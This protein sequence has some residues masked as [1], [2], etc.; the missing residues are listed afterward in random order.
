MALAS[1][2]V[3]L[4]PSPL[5]LGG[6]WVNR[7]RVVFGPLHGCLLDSVGVERG[8]GRPGERPWRGFFG[9]GSICD[10]RFVGFDGF[11][12]VGGSRWQVGF[13][14]VIERDRLLGQV[15]LHI[16]GA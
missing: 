8:G 9:P 16:L 3:C 5:G 4:G 1:V 2:V 15:R 10:L 7:Y 13:G 14:V 6:E 11:I 12:R